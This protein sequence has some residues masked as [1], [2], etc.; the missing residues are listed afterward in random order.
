MIALSLKDIG[1]AVLTVTVAWGIVHLLD[2]ISLG[3]LTCRALHN[4]PTGGLW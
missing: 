4:C 1:K 2:R 3:I